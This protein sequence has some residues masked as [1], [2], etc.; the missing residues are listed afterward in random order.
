MDDLNLLF[1]A[2]IVIMTLSLLWHVRKRFALDAQQKREQQELIEEA[3]EKEMQRRKQS[4]QPVKP[5]SGTAPKRVPIPINKTSTPFT[6]M[7]TPQNIAQWEVEIDQIRRTVNAQIDTKMLALQTLTLEADRA[8]SRLEVL[9]DHLE[10]LI[11]KEQ[12]NN[13]QDN[14]PPIQNTGHTDGYADKDY[15]EETQSS[16]SIS[17]GNLI[18]NSEMENLPAK[19]FNEVIGELEEQITSEA[20]REEP[21]PVKIISP[22]PAETAIPASA[23]ANIRIQSAL[24][25]PNHTVPFV[26]PPS[27]AVKRPHNALSLETLYNDGTYTGGN[28]TV[29]NKSDKAVPEPASS[30]H[31]SLRKQVELLADNG[32][33]ANQI[34]QTLNITVG[35]VDLM[36]NLRRA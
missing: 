16:E 23:Q 2:S 26:K 19:P 34:A 29:H 31:L 9:I 24:S 33:T 25:S 28:F 35:E 30:P 27:K 36:L 22:P 11:K 14:T 32:C 5:K 12:G 7:Y 15:E 4:G 10:K 8:A 18:R 21:K 6:G 20:I 13:Q 1:I 3:H 17:G